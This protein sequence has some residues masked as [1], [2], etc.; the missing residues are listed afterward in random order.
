MWTGL[1]PNVIYWHLLHWLCLV[2][3]CPWPALDFPSPT[4]SA[5][6]VANF[7][8]LL[9]THGF[10]TPELNLPASLLALPPSNPRAQSGSHHSPQEPWTTN[11]CSLVWMFSFL[12]L[13][14]VF[15]NINCTV[16]HRGI[17]T[18]GYNNILWPYPIFLVSG[19][20]HLLPL[21]NLSLCFLYSKWLSE[22]HQGCFSGL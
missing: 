7:L 20:H 21:P 1:V 9:Q 14:F 3:H 22:F 16:E 8:S 2:S 13:T 10:P 12:V 17:S 4:S 6:A 11:H 5:E 15:T 18:Q 19:S